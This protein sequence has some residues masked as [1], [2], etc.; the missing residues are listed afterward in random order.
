MIAPVP[1]LLKNMGNSIILILIYSLYC[2]KLL[3]YFQESEADK[4][5]QYQRYNEIRAVLSVC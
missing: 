2:A 5:T 4:M 1:I 3:L